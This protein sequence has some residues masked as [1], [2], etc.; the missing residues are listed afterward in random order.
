M[1]GEVCPH[2]F[3]DHPKWMNGTAVVLDDNDS[4]MSGC[5]ES[6]IACPKSMSRSMRVHNHC[7]QHYMYS[8]IA[9]PRY[10]G[11]CQV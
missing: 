3:T 10:L 9:L 2:A 1:P 11:T 8:I 6:A 4:Y 5:C 7:M